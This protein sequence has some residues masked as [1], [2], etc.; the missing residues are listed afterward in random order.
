M[1]TKNMQYNEQYTIQ[2]SFILRTAE[3]YGM[4]WVGYPIHSSLNPEEM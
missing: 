3:T 1:T 2:G 4:F